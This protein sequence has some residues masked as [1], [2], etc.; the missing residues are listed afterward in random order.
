MHFH[1]KSW[2]LIKK[3][4]FNIENNFFKNIVCEVL[5][6]HFLERKEETTYLPITSNIYWCRPYLPILWFL[7]N[8]FFLCLLILQNLTRL[9]LTLPK[10]IVDWRLYFYFLLTILEAAQL[11][12]SADSL[13][14][15]LR[16]TESCW[17]L[18]KQC[19][20]TFQKWNS[21]KCL[22]FCIILAFFW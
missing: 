6:L 13:T 2:I 17:N 20:Q 8:Y 11:L 14:W 3:A 12:T 4:L 5:I 18:Q 21:K 16:M 10:I 1:C 7:S 9:C 15:L 22:I 19:Y